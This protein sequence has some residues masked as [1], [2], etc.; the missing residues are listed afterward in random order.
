MKKYEIIYCC[1]SCDRWNIS[2]KGCKLYNRNDFSYGW[3]NKTQAKKYIKEH[4]KN[5]RNNSKT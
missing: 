1:Q 2:Y 3:L 5:V 4:K